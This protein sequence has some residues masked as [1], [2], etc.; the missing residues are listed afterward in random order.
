M[1]NLINK[2]K[3]I[4]NVHHQSYVMLS[5]INRVDNLNNI[6]N[7]MLLISYYNKRQ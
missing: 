5:V 1:L 4:D 3:M 7:G 2:Y 6:V